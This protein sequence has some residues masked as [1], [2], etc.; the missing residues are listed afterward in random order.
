MEILRN[1]YLDSVFVGVTA[2]STNV[3]QDIWTEVYKKMNGN[4]QQIAYSLHHTINMGENG[5]T[6]GLKLQYI[7]PVWA[8]DTV[9]VLA[10]HE[11]GTN[12]DVRFRVAQH[13]EEGIVQG[14]DANGTNFYLTNPRAVIV[15]LNMGVV[16]GL[17]E[18]SLLETSFECMPNPVAN[19][20]Q[21]SYILQR[22]SS[23]NIQ[24]VDYNGRV[25]LE[26]NNEANPSEKNVSF[27]ATNQLKA[28]MYYVRLQTADDTVIRKF[29]KL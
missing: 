2:T 17:N 12:D 3:G 16:V 19:E 5:S 25:I 14:F 22:P 11:G 18:N 21:L 6:V 1:D 15:R 13:V 20:L 26:E 29:I 23:V 8:G 9:L 24:V 7:T 4:W 27:I 10:C 28:G